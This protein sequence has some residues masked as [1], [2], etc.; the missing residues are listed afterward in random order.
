MQQYRWVFIAYLGTALVAQVLIHRDLG[1]P[2][3]R[4]LMSGVIDLALVT[5]VVHR[6]GSVSTALPF[7]YLVIAALNAIVVGMRVTMVLV[8]VGSA[9]Y[10]GVLAAELVGVLPYAPDALPLAPGDRPEVGAALSAA[11]LFVLSLLITTTVIGRLRAALSRREAE[12]AASNAELEHLSQ[13][14]ALTQLYNRRFLLGRLALELAR[15]RRGQRAALLMIDLDH[16]KRV[17]DTL[18]HEGGDHV[19]ADVASALARGTRR[20]DVVARY[21]GDEFVMLMP[22]SDAAGAERAAQRIVEN[23]RAA[24]GAGNGRAVT[25]S[26]GATTARADDDVS[27]VLRRADELAYRAKRA[28][29]DRFES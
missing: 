15:V 29:G 24:T 9:L 1:R 27:A 17:N 25:A 16:F 12:L 8:G 2:T 7:L 11:G 26:V 4:G 10:L 3:V 19:L 14:D 5:F 20:V 21:G 6:L 13:H 22:D 18:G 28:G 23:V